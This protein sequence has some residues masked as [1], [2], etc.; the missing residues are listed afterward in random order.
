[1]SRI[2]VQTFESAPE[3]ARPTL[4][5]L[6]RQTGRLLNI[7][8]EMA[9]TPVVLAAYAGVSDALATQSSFNARTREA[10]ALAVGATDGCDYCP[11]AHAPAAITSGLNESE[12]FVIR[13]G[14]VEVDPKMS[15]LLAVVREAA[16]NYGEVADATWNAALQG[17]LERAGTVGGVHSPGA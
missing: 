13:R 7:H 3:Q 14:T 4:E 8:A 11:A 16:A 10:I 17:R 2:P 12:T 9:T 15:T 6:T 1:V 5:R